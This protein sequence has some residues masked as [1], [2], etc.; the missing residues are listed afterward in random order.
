MSSPGV[1]D[2]KSGGFSAARQTLHLGRAIRLVW[3]I[4]PGWAVMN[5]GLVIVQGLLPL[6][7]PY[8]MKRTIDALQAGIAVHAGLAAFHTVLFWVILA[9]AAALLT[10]LVG[11]LAGLAGQAQS[12]V[13]SDKV[14]DIVHSR[15]VAVDLEYYENPSYYDTMQRAQVEAASRPIG[16]VNRLLGIGR[17]GVS[18]I[19]V[20]GLLFAFSPLVALVL[21]CVA[22][23]G[24]LVQSL[25]ARRQYRLELEQTEK[26]RQASYYHFLLTGTWFAKEVRLFN[27]GSLFRSRFQTLRQQLRGARL[28]LTRRRTVAGLSAQALTSAAIFGS[29]AFFAYQAC[30]GTTTLGSL[31]MYYAIL[32]LAVASFSSILSGVAGLYEDNLFLSNFYK[33]LDLKPKITA[34]AKPL[35]CSPRMT[36][37]IAFH[38][39]GFAYP[40]DSRRVLDAVNLT[41]APG[42][43]IALVGENGSGKTTLVKLLCRLYDADSG[44]VTV[45]GI[46]IR[47]LD[48]VEWRRKVSVILQDYVQ[49]GMTA[50]ENIWLGD[51]ESDPDRGRIIRAAELSGSDSAIRRLPQGYDTPLGYQ[52]KRGRE[53]S[54]G[55]WQKVALARAFLRDSELVVLDEPTS[56][57]DPL[58]EA[59]VFEHFR[60]AIRGRSAVLI[61]HRFS[62][63]RMADYI[64]VLDHGRVAE[65]GTHQELLDLGGLYARLYSAQAARYQDQPRG[66]T[67]S[68]PNWPGEPPATASPPAVGKDRDTRS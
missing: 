42:Q 33:F 9:A 20:A 16:V 15:S 26:D 51:V 31:V 67:E 11:S 55:E 30:K 61:S 10:A 39:V 63:V 12:M 40:G 3:T 64:Y 5:L 54:I 28:A 14:T 57:L 47:Q 52:F 35:P 44:K 27:L 22:L 4:A 65:S 32:Q 43:V 38:D 56:S 21:F 48:P 62:T 53:L 18:L 41:I 6:L 66:R 60:R 17:S 58:A 8:F 45:D 13:F 24:A 2:S 7:A 29:L 46:D 37:G 68:P 25:Y 1:E 23:P 50:W 59:E 49:Y 34:P 19:G 36:Q